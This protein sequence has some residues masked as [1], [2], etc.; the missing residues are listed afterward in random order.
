MG[1]LRGQA[2]APQA[3]VRERRNFDNLSEVLEF[4]NPDSPIVVDD[5]GYFALTLGDPSGL[6]DT[7]GELAVAVQGV[8]GLDASGVKLNIGNGLENDTDN[9]AV[10]LAT[11]SGLEFE[12]GDLRVRVQADGGIAREATG[13][14]ISG[15]TSAGDILT[16]NG[17]AVTA[18]APGTDG[19]PLIAASGQSVGL[20]YAGN[21]EF[22]NSNSSGDGTLTI[23]GTQDI[24]DVT[25]PHGLV[26]E[27]SAR[28]ATWAD[29]SRFSTIFSG[30]VQFVRDITGVGEVALVYLITSDG[31][32]RV[33]DMR[34]D[35]VRTGV[36]VVDPDGNF[37]MG[38]S[39]FPDAS[40]RLTLDGDLRVDGVTR[41]D[42]S[43]TATEVILDL[44]TS[45]TFNDAGGTMS[46][47]MGR[48]FSSPD[49]TV[50]F[51]YLSASGFGVDP[52]FFVKAGGT[53]VLRVADTGRVTVKDILNL[54]PSAEPSSPSEGD[55]YFD[56]STKKLRVYDGTAW[57]NLH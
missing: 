49:R 2:R 37:R 14:R 52:A 10:S 40:Y 17:S 33:A 42:A 24:A 51:G 13:L 38:D 48:V 15:L 46:I 56:T 8:I 29:G 4:I 9:L 57:A 25:G 36:F 44:R 31:N 12:L 32:T 26:V 19:A 54:N 39:D 45:A 30:G 55:V 53:E 11:D 16:H 43:S 41:Q 3:P 5:D 50:E 22:D 47:F 27:G 18:L 34:V 7:G 23:H 6:S 1:G 21:F 20:L 28:F 35:T